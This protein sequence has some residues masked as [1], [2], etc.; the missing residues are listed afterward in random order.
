MLTVF[1]KDLL[2]MELKSYRT[3]NGLKQ[4]ELATILGL[5]RSTISFFENQQQL[6]STEVLN[7]LCDLIGKPVEHFFVQ[8]KKDPLMLMM[9]KMEESDKDTLIKVIERIKVRKKYISLSKR[10][11]D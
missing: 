5:N 9:G 11:G 8:E 2:A 4:S 7:R 6:P 10:L 1:D 3:N